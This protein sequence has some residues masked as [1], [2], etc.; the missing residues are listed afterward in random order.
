MNG[1]FETLE[2]YFHHIDL[3]DNGLGGPYKRTTVGE[4]VPSPLRHL[5]AALNYLRRAGAI[6]TSSLFLDAGCGDARV[7]A[8]T[9]LVHNIPSVGVE[10]DEE[11]VERSEHHLRGLKRLGLQGTPV[12]IVH[13]DF[14]DDDTYLRAGRRFEDFATVFNYVNNERAV[15]EKVAQQSPL[16]AKLL[17]FGAFPLQEYGGLLL[18]HNLELAAETG[19]SNAILA[20]SH[21]L[22]QD[23]HIDPDATYLQVYRKEPSADLRKDFAG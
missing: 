4:F 9:A 19:L 5:H 15:A 22:T 18:E 23:A 1:P 12:I 21:P 8:L 17:L 2:D 11:L 10:Y 20:R 7:V 13:G 14:R 6:D 16:G 3:R